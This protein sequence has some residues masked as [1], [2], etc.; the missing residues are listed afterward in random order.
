ML[1]A[2][3][4]LKVL[5]PVGRTQSDEGLSPIGGTLYEIGKIWE[6]EGEEEKRVVKRPQCPFPIPMWHLGSEGEVEESGL[7]LSLGRLRWG[8]GG[9]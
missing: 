3:E 8:V 5:Q 1:R 2:R 7:R 9:R 6:E 4:L